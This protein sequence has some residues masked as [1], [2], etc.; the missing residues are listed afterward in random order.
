[1]L[2]DFSD[3]TKIGNSMLI[4]R[5]AAPICVYICCKF[6]VISTFTLMLT[7]TLRSYRGQNCLL[8]EVISAKWLLEKYFPKKLSTTIAQMHARMRTCTHSMKQPL[9]TLSSIYP[10]YFIV[11]PIFEADGRVHAMDMKTRLLRE[12][13]ACLLAR[14]PIYPLS[15][16][17]CMSNVENLFREIILK[18]KKKKKKKK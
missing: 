7:N 17:A 1:M 15:R 9:K 3:H 11:L 14:L 5:C 8:H 18:K 12:F 2:L 6:Y 16:S 13:L 4:S 10:I